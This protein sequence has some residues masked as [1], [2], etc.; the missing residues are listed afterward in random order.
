MVTDIYSNIFAADRKHLAQQ[1]NE[2][3]FCLE[4]NKKAAE[5]ES[6]VDKSTQKLIQ[7]LQI[8]PEQAKKLLQVYELISG[9]N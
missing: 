9:N 2:Q 4:A 1:V 8:A 7:L 5:P 3:F 6:D